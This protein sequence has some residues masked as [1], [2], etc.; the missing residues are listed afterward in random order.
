MSG[1]V[2]LW[3]DKKHKRYYIGS[4]WGNP[5]DGYICSSDSMR[6]AYRRR[7]KDFRR[8]ILS[9]I[10]TNRSD[11][12]T[13][14]QRWLDMIKPEE[15]GIRYYNIS[16][17]VNKGYWWINEETKRQ[18]GVKISKS[19]KGKPIHTKETK[20]K[21]SQIMKDYWKSGK[22]KTKTPWN[23]GLKTGPQ[24]LEMIE[25]RAQKLRGKK[26][27]PFSL[28]TR[29]KMSISAKG[30]LA[31]NKGL[32]LAWITNGIQDKQIKLE[33]ISKFDSSWKR[34]RTKAEKTLNNIEL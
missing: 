22:L 18:V 31:W 11:L 9:F 30:R 20:Q 26:L 13:E 33:N 4:H 23:K 24:P 8:R 32:S 19:T 28:E 14:E 7:S 1:F 12:L 5:N 25:K 2:Y 16:S 21:L 17:K 27:K 34:G 29:Q 10:I 15:F 6:E 3:F